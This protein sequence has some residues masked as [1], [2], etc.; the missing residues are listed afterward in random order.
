VDGFSPRERKVVLEGPLDIA[1]QLVQTARAHPRG[2]RSQRIGPSTGRRAAKDRDG[3][4]TLTRSLTERQARERDDTL[5][6]T[7]SALYDSCSSHVGDDG[8]A[9]DHIHLLR[10]RSCDG[11]GR[12][13]HHDDLHL[14]R[15]GHLLSWQARH[16]QLP[17]SQTY[18]TSASPRRRNIRRADYAPHSLTTRNARATITDPTNETPRPYHSDIGQLSG[19]R[20]RRRSG[21]ITTKRTSGQLG[22]GSDRRR[23]HHIPSAEGEPGR[24]SPDGATT[25]F[26]L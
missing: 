5:S 7:R 25:T 4:A 8:T 16:W 6:T 26:K 11:V 15:T 17:Y 23:R 24:S 19:S 22:D 21:E 18:A 1:F 20:T 2:S 3:A 14:R 9:V 13:Q 12:T 10:L